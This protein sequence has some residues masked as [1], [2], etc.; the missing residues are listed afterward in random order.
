MITKIYD[1]L[2]PLAGD[3][4]RKQQELFN[5]RERQD[6]MA[7]WLFKTKEFKAWFEATGQTMWCIG[8]RMSLIL[9]FRP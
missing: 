6:G 5:T 3:F 1:W 2:S 9:L 7:R 8:M 4:E